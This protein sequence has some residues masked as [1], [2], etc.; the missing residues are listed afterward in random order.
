MPIGGVPT[1]PDPNT[2]ARLSRY[3][4]E[5]YRDTNW[6]CVCTTFSHEEGI[7][8]QKH[9]ERN[10]RCIAILF[11]SIRITGRFGSPELRPSK[12]SSHLRLVLDRGLPHESRQSSAR[13]H[14]RA[15]THTRFEVFCMALH[16]FGSSLPRFVG[17]FLSSLTS[18]VRHP[19][20]TKNF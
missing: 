3:K 13:T 4:W 20:T 7:L 14:A 18:L 15:H 5:P 2:L 17:F 6:W 1:T 11:E 16:V 10:G 12:C 8:L 19:S 9:R